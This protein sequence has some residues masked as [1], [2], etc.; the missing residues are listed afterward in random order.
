[1]ELWRECGEGVERKKQGYSVVY[2][3]LDSR[4]VKKERA[5]Y[6]YLQK[7]NGGMVMH[8]IRKSAWG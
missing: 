2:Y 4:Y 3:D 7:Q 1:M 8:K 5:W 6:N